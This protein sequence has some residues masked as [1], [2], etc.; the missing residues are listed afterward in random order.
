MLRG[1]AFKPRTRPYAF[2]GLAEGLKILAEAREETGLPIVT[3]VIDPREVEPV[4][5]RGRAP[6]RRPQHA[7]LHPARRGGGAQKPVLLKRGWRP[8]SRNS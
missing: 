4:L 8:R 7:E 2:Q 3:E 1:G 6:D 5:E